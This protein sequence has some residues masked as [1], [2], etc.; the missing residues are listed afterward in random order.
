M[1]KCYVFIT[2]GQME[3]N[4]TEKDMVLGVYVA[5]SEQE[6]ITAFDKA[7]PDIST[8]DYTVVEQ[9]LTELI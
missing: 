9:E 3:A 1:K 4:A 8:D 5:T 2:T 7:L 6:A